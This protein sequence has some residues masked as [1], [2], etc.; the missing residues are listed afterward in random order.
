MLEAKH[1]LLLTAPLLAVA[2][3]GGGA[4]YS[5]SAQHVDGRFR[6][7][8]P[9][10]RHGF[11]RVARH[12]LF[13]RNGAWPDE[14]LKAANRLQ[15]D[16][17][18]KKGEAA[19]TFVGHATVLVQL[20]GLNLLTDPVWSDVVGPW[21]WVGPERARDP[22]IPFDR[23][24]RIDVVLIS[25][26]HYDHLDLPT[27]KRLAERLGAV[28]IALLPIGAYAPREMMHTHHINPAEAVQAQ[29]DLGAKH[30]VAIHYGAFQLTA[31]DFDAPVKALK[32]A[33]AKGPT[34]PG[35]FHVIPE[36]ETRFLSARSASQAAGPQAPKHTSQT[37]KIP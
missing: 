26:N 11:F 31:E 22:G 18:L 19:V 29:R 24:P 16:R 9:I 8:V 7:P 36:G 6:N 3:C 4:A 30:A 12:I 15:L 28:D 17:T 20:A 32:A 14:R 1:I 23:L 34:P 35:P 27:L 37:P 33:L 21:G 13:G 25:H 5:G 10:E 2:G